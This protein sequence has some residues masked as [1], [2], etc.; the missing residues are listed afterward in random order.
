MISRRI[1]AA[2]ALLC[3]LSAPAHTQTGSFPTGA[4]A[5]TVP[6][7]INGVTLDNAAWSTYTPN[8]A[9]STVGSTPATYTVNSARYKRIGKTVT[10]SV[11]VTVTDQ[12]VGAAGSILI[13]LPFAA[14]SAT[15]AAWVGTSYEFAINGRSG[16]AFVTMGGT[17]MQCRDA[18]ATTYIATNNAI[19]AEVTYEIP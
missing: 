2:A 19:V 9:S 18:T 8:V 5:L 4:G 11:V 10:V 12:G 6:G 7:T 17:N 13:D 14:S 1:L 15:N 16:R 3:A